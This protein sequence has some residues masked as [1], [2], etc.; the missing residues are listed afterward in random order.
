M[1]LM[2]TC[3]D[4]ADEGKEDLEDV[5]DED[6]REDPISQVDLRVRVPPG[7]RCAPLTRYGRFT[8]YSLFVNAHLR[9]R[10]GSELL[11]QG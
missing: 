4:F 8:C 1:F 11:H 7:L 10:L 2:R 5:L 9:T 3:V 6:L